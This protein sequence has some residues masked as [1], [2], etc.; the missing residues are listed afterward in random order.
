MKILGFDQLVH[1]LVLRAHF[2]HGLDPLGLSLNRNGRVP[3]F[4]AEHLFSR[5]SSRIDL[6][7]ASTLAMSE[8]R[9]FT[10]SAAIAGVINLPVSAEIELV[11]AS[12]I[13][14]AIMWS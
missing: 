11:A 4:D 8:R 6:G 2:G 10:R 3:R 9:S 12:L 14:Q 5:L 13:P 1:G 7:H